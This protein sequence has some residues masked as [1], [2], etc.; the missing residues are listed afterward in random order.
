[1]SL[2]KIA[3]LLCAAALLASG[4]YNEKGG[5]MNSPEPDIVADPLLCDPDDDDF[6]V[7]DN[8]PCVPGAIPGCGQIG[9]WPV[10]CGSV[11]VESKSWS[12][13]KGLYR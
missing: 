4:D 3:T 2:T 9:A 1:M 12:Q 6:T 10:G 7:Q 8:S 5:W 13:I 11:H